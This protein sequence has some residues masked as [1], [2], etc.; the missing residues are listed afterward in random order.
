V[1]RWKLPVVFRLQERSTETP[2]Y[3]L[4]EDGERLEVLVCRVCGCVIAS[5]LLLLHAAKMHGSARPYVG[6]Q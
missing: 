1:S 5:K 3:M 6:R 2:D 4:T